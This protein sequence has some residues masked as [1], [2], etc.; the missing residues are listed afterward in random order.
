MKVT[1]GCMVMMKICM[2]MVMKVMEVM[3]VM[4]V[5]GDEN[6]LKKQQAKPQQKTTWQKPIA[7]QE[8][9]LSNDRRL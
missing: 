6:A 2:C 3:E 9:Q 8:C 1:W 7:Y 4:E 5:Y